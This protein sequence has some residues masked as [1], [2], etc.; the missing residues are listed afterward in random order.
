MIEDIVAFH[1]EIGLLWGEVFR[2]TN[3]GFAGTT[4]MHQHYVACPA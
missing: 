1:D 3:L 2:Q 4:R